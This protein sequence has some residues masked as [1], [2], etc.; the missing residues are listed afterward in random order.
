MNDRHGNLEGE[1][2]LRLYEATEDGVKLWIVSGTAKRGGK[3]WRRRFGSREAAEEFLARRMRNME[4]PAGGAE[5]VFGLRLE[6][7]TGAA[8]GTG[9]P[10]DRGAVSSARRRKAKDRNAGRATGWKLLLVIPAIALCLIVDEKLGG[11]RTKEKGS[12]LISE[13]F[14]KNPSM[15]GWEVKGHGGEWV[16]DKE[17]KMERSMVVGDSVLSSPSVA[18][19]G[20]EWYKLALRSKAHA[21]S[22]DGKRDFR[23]ECVVRFS[24]TLESVPFAEALVPVSELQEWRMNELRFRVPSWPRVRGKASETMM[25]LEFSAKGGDG[26]QVDDVLVEKT[27]GGEVGRWADEMYGKLAAELA[28]RP[29]ADRWARLPETLRKLRSHQRVRLAFVGGESMAQLASAPIDVFLERMYPGA[30]VEILGPMHRREGA[31]ATEAS[32]RE[33]L[34][35]GGADLIVFGG[36]A[37]EQSRREFGLLT[38]VVRSHNEVVGDRVEILLITDGWNKGEESA[39][40]VRLSSDLREL[41]QDPEKNVVLPDDFRAQ[42]VRRAATSNVEF[43]DA[44]GIVSEFVFGPAA[45]AKTGPPTAPDGVPDLFR[46]R[47]WLHAAETGRQVM[48]RILEAFFRPGET[49]PAKR[50]FSGARV[51]FFDPDSNAQ[52]RATYLAV[53]SVFGVTSS[54][55]PALALSLGGGPAFTAKGEAIGGGKVFRAQGQAIREIGYNFDEALDVRAGDIALYWSFRSDRSRG[56]E[57]GKLTA[58]LAYSD[59]A[60]GGREDRAQI[61]VVVKPGAAAILGLSGGSFSEEELEHEVEAPVENFTDMTRVAKF[62]LVVR[63]AGGDRVVAE[64]A[65]WNPRSNRWEAFV[66]FDRPGAPPLVME[67][68]IERHLL[69]VPKFSALYFEAQSEVPILDSVLVMVRPS[70]IK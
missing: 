8:T 31:G 55:K 66:P 35:A 16:M 63:W 58:H 23:G 21:F 19:V 59:P 28:Y 4:L 60:Q 11:I 6:R 70:I 13:A 43:L 50:Q 2:G 41:D 45:V 27:T 67:M 46:V 24:H 18:V 38:E 34:M 29:K 5:T 14:E 57:P 39:A 40:G 44:M 22:E 69:G 53:R 51:R 48:G 20:G 65:S 36:T 9:E 61:S 10:L 54:D 33:L 52:D 25:R 17:Q 62:R 7:G 64:A 30:I 32:F 68:S 1:D 49:A 15:S 42:W 47:D 26:F 12:A 3:R 56:V 37:E